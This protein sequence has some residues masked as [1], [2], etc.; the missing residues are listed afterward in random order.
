[1][2]K[3]VEFTIKLNVD[4]KE[5]VVNARADVNRLAEELGIAKTKS[6]ETRNALLKIN[7]AAQSVQN[8]LAGL[9]QITGLMSELTAANTMQVEAE[10]K[11]ANNM[12]NTMGARQED[13]Q[14]IYDL[15]AAQQQLGVIGD[16]VQLAGAQELATYLEKKSSLERLIPVMNDMLAQQF[17]L[18]ATGEEAAQI[19]SMLGK[20]MDGQVGAL[21]RY[22]YNFDAAQEQILKFG[23]EEQRAAVLAEVVE[24]AVGGMNAELAKT[25]AGRAKQMA[26]A[27]GDVKELVG[28]LLASVEPGIVAFGELCTA[29]GSIGTTVQGLQGVATALTSGSIAAKGMTIATYAQT[30]AQKVGTVVQA[31]WAKQLYYGRQAQ[32]AWALSAKVATVQAIAMRGAILGLMAVT[33]V[34]LAFVAV[35]SIVSLFASK[36]DDAT[37]SMKDAEAEARRMA[38]SQDEE[39]QAGTRAAATLALQQ[40]KLKNLIEAKQTGKNVSAEEKKT[41]DALN[42]AYGETM[43]YFSSVADWYKALVANSEDYCRQMVIEAKTRRLANEAAEA[44]MKADELR[45]QIS[46]GQLSEKRQTERHAVT[47]KEGRVAYYEDREIEGSSELEQAMAAQMAAMAEA[48]AKQEQMRNAVA[49]AAT[50]SFKVKGSSTRQA[51]GNTG[52]GAKKEKQL[53]ENASTYREL[54]NNVEYYQQ[55]L[56]KCDITDT[57]RIVTLAKAKKT[58]EQAVQTFRDVAEAAAMPDAPD[59]LE[60]YDR[61]LQLLGRQRSTAS[62]EQAV[63]IDRQINKVEQERKAYE[64][65]LTRQSSI[66]TLEHDQIATRDQLNAKMAYYNTLM[67]QGTEADRKRARQGIDELNE[68]AAAWDAAAAK[69][70]FGLDTTGEIDP[71]ALHSLKGVDAAIQLYTEQQQREDAGQVQKTQ[72]LIDRL[73]QRRQAIRLGI[74]LPQMEREVAELKAL[75]GREYRLKIKATGFEALTEKLR[76]LNRQLANPDLTDEQRRQLQQ[77][78]Q[79]YAAFASDAAHSMETYRSGWDGLKGIGSG[80][81]AVSDALSGQADA[82]QV[83]TAVVDAAL[84]VYDG[85][86]AIVTMIDTLTAATRLTQQTEQA[87]T[88]TTVAGSAATAADTAV[89]TANTVATELN[90]QAALKNAAANGTQAIT[91]VTKEGAKLPFP[92]SLA[93]IAAGLAAVVAALG[94]AGAFA[95][96]GIV[97]GSSPTGDRLLARVNSGEMILNHQ[98][99]ARLFQALTGPLPVALATGGLVMGPTMALIG[100]YAGAARNPEVVAP[101][102]RLSAMLEPRQQQPLRV[103]FKIEGRN[104]VGVL[105]NESLTGAHA[106]RRRVRVE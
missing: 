62:S 88:A 66:A 80:I 4:G 56:E 93:A 79:D 34:G 78:R 50:I 64:L 26:N 87:K 14:S 5:H 17:G 85:V 31:L 39:A 45:R 7:N 1:M 38:H 59:T 65:Q 60:A 97:G 68:M 28:D 35:S 61:Q 73:T 96:G 86:R 100:E 44:E 55:E 75:T 12:R 81:Q 57:E 99:Q 74:E 8:A 91:E 51:S 69:S 46:S 71:A 63:A 43:G 6:D 36:T 24:S 77:L 47:N 33:G 103:R 70:Q 15:C 42:D 40:E 95:D 98:Q 49:E 54:A 53:I 83:L 67:T 20:V 92:A 2:A 30:A 19:A 10:T 9:Q 25:D 94:M 102:D 16:E 37:A 41:V 89:T 32:I 22:G 21:S 106:G 82:W 27:I 58:A 29:V 104:L 52:K 23:T 101:L 84:Q 18:N 48:A 11:L 3:N 13:I 76:D 90:T 72:A 105:A